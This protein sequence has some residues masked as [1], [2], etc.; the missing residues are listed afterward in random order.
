VVVENLRQLCVHR[1][2]NASNRPWV[3]WDYV[4]DYHL[5]CSMTENKYTRR[6]AEDVVR[7]L[8][9]RHVLS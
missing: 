7:S 4:A 8:G 9:A 3:W 6:C 2:A 1:V 5:R